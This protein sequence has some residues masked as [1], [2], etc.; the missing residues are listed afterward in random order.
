MHHPTIFRTLEFIKNQQNPDGSFHSTTFNL[1]DKT[2]KSTLTPFTTSLI[3][4]CLKDF[5]DYPIV[6]I[7]VAKGIDFLMGEKSENWSWNYWPRNSREMREHPCP[8]DLDDTFCAL[9]A[10]TIHKPELITPKAFVKI[11]ESLM[12]TEDQVGGPY[13]TWLIDFKKNKVWKDIDIVVNMNI[14][15]FL[16]LHGVHL[17]KLDRFIKKT[18]KN[19]V[20]NKKSLSKYYSPS[21]IKYL[22]SRLYGKI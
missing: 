6:K 2:Q 5:K 16:K 11:T 9:T 12:Q 19:S 17:P 8:D 13:N 4:C 18:I 21:I 3:L 1:K 22:S 20:I 15:Y 14:S 7:I 10:I